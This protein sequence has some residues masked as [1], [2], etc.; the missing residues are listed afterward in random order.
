MVEFTQ[1][2]DRADLTPDQEVA[3]TRARALVDDLRAVCELEAQLLRDEH[4]RPETT[5]DEA[6]KCRGDARHSRS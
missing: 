6:R 5:T 1:N 4:A 2:K 3:M